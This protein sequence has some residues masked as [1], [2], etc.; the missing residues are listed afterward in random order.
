[1]TVRRAYDLRKPETET[2]DFQELGVRIENDNHKSANIYGYGGV[3]VRRDFMVR[4]YVQR[5]CRRQADCS[6]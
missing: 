5:Y 2:S 6:G 4:N 3:T 1:M